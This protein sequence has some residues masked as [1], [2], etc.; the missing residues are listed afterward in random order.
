MKTTK[1]QPTGLNGLVAF[2]IPDI[3]DSD[4]GTVTLTGQF[5]RIKPNIGRTE[6]DPK[7]VDELANKYCKLAT[8]TGFLDHHFKRHSI[9]TVTLTTV[10]LSLYWMPRVELGSKQMDFVIRFL[11]WLFFWDDIMEQGW[12]N[13]E[14]M[15]KKTDISMLRAINGIFA[16]ILR[17]NEVI[18]YEK[19]TF[20]GYPQFVALCV[21]VEDFLQVAKDILRERYSTQVTNVIKAFQ[22]YADAIEWF[23]VNP[24]D[25][26]YETVGNN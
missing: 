21:F 18:E 16:D 3:R 23:T 15:D 13:K 7:I 25:G 19:L 24:V 4:K 26:R 9:K 6:V 5:Q 17:G 20:P 2:E 14:K 8:N 1:Y 11:T 10:Q 12:L 22:S